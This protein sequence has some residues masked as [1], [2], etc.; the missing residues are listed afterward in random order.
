MFVPISGAHNIKTTKLVSEIADFYVVT[1][2][3]QESL[4]LELNLIK[5]HIT[6]IQHCL[7]DIKHIHLLNLIWR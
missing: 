6:K 1:N 7:N 2:S 3:E 4:I 5:Q